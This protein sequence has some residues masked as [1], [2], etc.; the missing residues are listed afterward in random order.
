MACPWE[1]MGN[2]LGVVLSSSAYSGKAFQAYL[3]M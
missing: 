3:A 1:C 2:Y